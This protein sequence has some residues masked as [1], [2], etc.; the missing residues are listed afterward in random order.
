M[1]I[2]RLCC[3]RPVL[4]TAP[5]RLS[6]TREVD[7][8]GSWRALSGPVSAESWRS[9]GTVHGGGDWKEG[10]WA[11]LWTGLRKPTRDSAVGRTPAGGVEGAGGADTPTSALP[12]AEAKRRPRQESLLEAVEVSPWDPGCPAGCRVGL[13]WGQG[14]QSTQCLLKTDLGWM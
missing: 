1:A 12:W 9:G 11:Q 8:S 7:V 5:W 14:A 13:G 10:L 4:P 3:G 2:C 6:G